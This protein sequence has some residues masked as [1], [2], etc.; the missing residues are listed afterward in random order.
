LFFESHES[1]VAQ[2]FSLGGLSFEQFGMQSVQ[3]QT[4]GNMKTLTLKRIGVA[5]AF[6]AIIMA[7]VLQSC[8]DSFITINRQGEH[9]QVLFHWP[10]ILAV[11][12]HFSGLVCLSWPSSSRRQAG[13]FDTQAA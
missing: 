13:R 3:Q 6:G 1:A 5:L 9:G 12:L 4:K 7:I 10:V 8:T 2:L 11:L